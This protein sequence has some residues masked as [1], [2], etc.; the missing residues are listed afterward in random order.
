MTGDDASNTVENTTRGERLKLGDRKRL[1]REKH[2]IGR[3][4]IT[5]GVIRRTWL[6]Y[7]RHKIRLGKS[8]TGANL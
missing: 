4:Q 8:E 7:S 5:T 6:K 2:L 1:D 3:L